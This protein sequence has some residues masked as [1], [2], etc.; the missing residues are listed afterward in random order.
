VDPIRFADFPKYELTSVEDDRCWHGIHTFIEAVV[1]AVRGHLNA[2][3]D[4]LEHKHE[5]GQA[6][7]RALAVGDGARQHDFSVALRCC[8][9]PGFKRGPDPTLQLPPHTL[10]FF[11]E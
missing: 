3:A 7:S 8:V 11:Y 9:V 6:R 4:P 10:T 2:P 1:T 5:H